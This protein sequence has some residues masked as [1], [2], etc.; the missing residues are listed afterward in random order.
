M[1]ERILR[2]HGLKTG[3][4]TSPHLVNLGERVQINREEL[5]RAEILRRIQ[6]LR[7]VV[8]GIFNPSERASYPSFLSI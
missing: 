8:D 5:S 1:L 6:A 3:M 4:F 2:A 7:K